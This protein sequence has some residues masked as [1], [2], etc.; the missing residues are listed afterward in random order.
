[1][2]YKAALKELKGN[3]LAT[4]KSAGFRGGHQAGA[5]RSVL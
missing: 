4:T 1:M 3:Q 2:D 5:G